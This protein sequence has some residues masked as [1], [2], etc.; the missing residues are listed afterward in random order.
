MVSTHQVWRNSIALSPL[1]QPEKLRSTGQGRNR[2]ARTGRHTVG[3]QEAAAEGGK[4]LFLCASDSPARPGRPSS[5][6]SSQHSA[7]S[8]HLSAHATGASGRAG[9][10]A[11]VGGTRRREPG[12]AGPD[13]LHGTLP[14]PPGAAACAH[15]A[16]PDMCAAPRA[17]SPP[18]ATSGGPTPRGPDERQRAHPAEI[19]PHLG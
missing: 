15:T 16:S 3:S 7:G 13:P 10:A 19:P 11:E 6:L 1:P 2:G 8:G 9:L 4:A 14:R 12:A 18:S 17:P 5:I